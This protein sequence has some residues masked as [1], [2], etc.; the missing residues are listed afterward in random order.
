MKLLPAV[1]TAAAVALAAGCG[2]DPAVNTGPFGGSNS[3]GG[4]CAPVTGG[5]SI[6]AGEQFGN[7]GSQVAVIKSVSLWHNNGLQLVSA[8]VLLIHNSEGLGALTYPPVSIAAW[9]KRVP[10]VGARI[11]PSHGQEVYNLVVQLRPLRRT[12]TAQAVAVSYESGGAAYIMR[13]NFAWTITRGR[14]CTPPPG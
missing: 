8:W 3:S 10:A 7:A 9:P 13:Q 14:R 4:A 11:A 6:A 1:V 2:S 12:G 5:G